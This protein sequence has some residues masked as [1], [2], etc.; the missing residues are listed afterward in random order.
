MT[1]LN[2]VWGSDITYLR[3]RAGFFLYLAVFLD[4]YSRR[5]VGWQVSSSLCGEL[6]LRAFD[7]AL[8]TRSVRGGLMIH[9]DRGCQYTAGEFR[10]RLEEL[11]FVQSFSRTGNCY[12]NAYCE[13]C[14][15]LLKRELGS[16]V[17]R[18]VNEARLDIF[19]WIEGW[20]NTHRLHSLWA[21]EALWHLRKCLLT[22]G[23][24]PLNFSH[25]SPHTTFKS[26][27]SFCLSRAFFLFLIW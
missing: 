17:Y 25:F 10:R 18:S 5:I 1:G 8:R 19:E 15:S 26:A 24:L 21:I 20:Y 7:R 23:E 22:K 11:G 4:F 9:S 16:K 2:Q 12:D 14:F 13:S 27:S 3:M 6:V